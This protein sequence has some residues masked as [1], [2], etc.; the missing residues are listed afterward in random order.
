MI[1]CEGLVLGQP[2]S[3]KE[4]CRSNI[5]LRERSVLEYGYLS[6]LHPGLPCLKRA[7]TKTLKLWEN[8]CEN[9]QILENTRETEG[10]RCAIME[11]LA[12]AKNKTLQFKVRMTFQEKQ[13]NQPVRRNAYTITGEMTPL[14]THFPS[15]QLQAN[16]GLKNI[17]YCLKKDGIPILRPGSC[18]SSFRIQ[19]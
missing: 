6:L 2:N 4:L 13:Q 7:E 10:R 3:A 14:H 11:I 16:Q 19:I 12:L 8:T 9:I 1:T 5:L 15:K 18:I 17:L